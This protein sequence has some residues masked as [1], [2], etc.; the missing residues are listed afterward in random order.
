M[1]ERSATM[2][3]QLI[4]TWLGLPPG[5]W[6]PDHY[7]LLGLQPG[8]ANV[9][10]IEQRVHELLMRLRSYQ[11]SHPALA[12]EAMMRLAKAFDCLT[13]P[14]LKKAY[15]AA[16]FPH[17]TLPQPAARVPTALASDTTETTPVPAPP[18][19]DTGSWT[20]P[21]LDWKPAAAAPPVRI[22]GENVEPSV[23][24]PAASVA[25]PEPPP[26][27]VPVEAAEAAPVVP[28]PLAVP[29]TPPASP[30]ANDLSAPSP[31][32]AAAPKI[33]VA[34]PADVA[35]DASQDS[36]VLGTRR[37]VYERVLWTRQALRAWERAGKY[38]GKPKRRLTKFAEEAELARVLAALDELLQEVPDLLGQP[39]QAAYRVLA[40]ARQEPV[41]DSFKALDDGQRDA[42]ARDW[43]AGRLFLLAHRRFLKQRIRALRH[44]TR[45]QRLR[46]AVDAA[47]TDHLKWVLLALGLLGVVILVAVCLMLK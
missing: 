6:P 26:I 45:G 14:Q 9:E 23:P 36:T 15:D 1:S 21:P 25:P 19:R 32:P 40:L 35:I 18:A 38:L 8:E 17:L 37:R 3:Y 47:L 43:I 16:Q 11:L 20:A 29:I 42:L 24:A 33:P 31:A 13:N 28:A 44:L 22:G 27:R 10:R 34:K 7:A 5:C 46:R 2:D 30:L 12:T 39:G 41:A 4:R